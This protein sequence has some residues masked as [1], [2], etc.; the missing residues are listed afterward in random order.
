MLPNFFMTRPSLAGVCT[1]SIAQIQVTKQPAQLHVQGHTRRNRILP[2][3]FLGKR[4]KILHVHVHAN[5]CKYM[6]IRTSY[7]LVLPSI[8]VITLN[9]EVK[10]SNIKEE[11]KISFT[12][13]KTTVGLSLLKN[14]CLLFNIIKLNNKL[15]I[16]D[17]KRACDAWSTA[18]HTYCRIWISS[19]Q[20]YF[21]PPV[22][23]SSSVTPLFENAPS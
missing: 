10:N 21:L 1:Y 19:V 22:A 16:A 4:T 14:I 12:P 17:Q 18:L 20:N 6:Q 2:C 8:S 3:L 11:G 9:Y 7:K 15:N 13:L 23:T 5:T